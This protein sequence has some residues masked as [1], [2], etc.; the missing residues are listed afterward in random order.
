MKQSFPVIKTK[1]LPT[2][3]SFWT[4][5][6][7]ATCLHYWN[8]PMWAVVGAPA[9]IFILRILRTLFEDGVDIFDGITEEKKKESNYQSKFQEKL[10]QMA[11]DRGINIYK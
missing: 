7:I 3:H 8:A 11:K 2:S 4:Y 1:N 5:F 9:L 10:N 6:F